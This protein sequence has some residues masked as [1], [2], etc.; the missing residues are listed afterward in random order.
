MA[1]VVTIAGLSSVVGSIA[2]D[3]A[4]GMTDRGLCGV[5]AD[6]RD[7]FAG[8]GKI[9]PN[10]DIARGVRLAHLQAMER[11]I[12]DFRD[13]NNPAWT[14]DRALRPDVFF[15]RS[16]NYLATQLGRSLDLSRKIDR[17]TS[18][19]IEHVIDDA[20]RAPSNDS[21]ESR[22]KVLRRVAEDAA[23]EEL[24]QHLN[25]ATVPPEFEARFRADSGVGWFSTFSTFLVRQIKTNKN[26]QAILTAG[27]LVELKRIG[28]TAQSLMA[29]IDRRVDD[30]DKKVEKIQ[31]DTGHLRDQMHR[32]VALMEKQAPR[33]ASEIGMPLATVIAILEEFGEKNVAPDAMI[34]EAKLR[35]KAA[36]YREL[37]T[38]SSSFS[39]DNPRAIELHQ[40]ARDEIDRGNFDNAESLLLKAEGVE[41]LAVEERMARHRE[42][43]AQMRAARAKLA[44]LRLDY[45]RAAILFVEAARLSPNTNVAAGYW[46][47]AALALM[48]Q[49]EDFGDAEA[50]VHSI[51]IL[52]E[53]LKAI[54][55]VEA[56]SPVRAILH[57][58]LGDALKVLGERR[59]DLG[60]LEEAAHAYNLALGQRPREMDASAW[61]ETQN[62]RGAILAILG[63]HKGDPTLLEKA[64]EAFRAALEVRTRETAPSDWSTSQNHLG[65]ALRI[66]AS[67]RE[68]DPTLLSASVDA[69]EQ[70]LQE[71]TLEREPL[72]WTLTQI[73]LA[74]SLCFLGARCQDEHLLE[75]AI[76]VLDLVLVTATPRRAPVQWASA[77][78]GLGISRMSLARLRRDEALMEAAISALEDVLQAVPRDWDPITWART[79]SNLGN[80]FLMLSRWRVDY[81]LAQDAIESLEE[82]LQTFRQTR[83]DPFVTS[84]RFMLEEAFNLSRFVRSVTLLREG[85]D[86]DDI[87]KF[88]EG[89]AVC[90]AMLTEQARD[91]NL[92]D[93][94]GAKQN[95]GIALYCIWEREGTVPSLREAI[96]AHREARDVFQQHGDANGVLAAT[97]ALARAESALASS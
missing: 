40:Q 36:E 14:A 2:I 58:D 52:R 38:P 88:H 13:A 94:A 4:G 34:L 95:L 6:V 63:E 41:T 83:A 8:R 74:G 22:S 75:R 24:M 32:L 45:G 59:G 29:D 85:M 92:L 18:A 48:R 77:M 30:L 11:V 70:S 31:S 28:L 19:S 49:G 82:A 67:L 61:A 53:I 21:A 37:I 25:G 57:V 97:R 87:G 73:N 50:L 54:P 12:K 93:W 60:M 64:I 3:V 1:D 35:K 81:R 9:P 27:Q 79:R 80:A 47:S 33:I 26:F 5:V 23:L 89:V 72:D 86:K 20:I 68:N 66:L 69:L 84:T 44:R 43:Q 76:A 42:V 17:T 16:E 15:S 78:N 10:E 91:C 62:C 65:V 71:R 56:A 96:A 55:T 39:G 46:R 7:A 51:G 90:R